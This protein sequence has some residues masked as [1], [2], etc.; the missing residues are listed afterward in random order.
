M[1]DGVS[2]TTRE[3][4]MS[5]L[6]PLNFLAIFEFLSSLYPRILR[7]LN[8]EAK[9]ED[10]VEAVSSLEKSK[11]RLKRAFWAFELLGLLMMPSATVLVVLASGVRLL[12]LLSRKPGGPAADELEVVAIGEGD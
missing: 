3:S 8:L 5:F 2:S 1:A 9:S 12:N 4:R 10:V 11:A 7:S 6:D